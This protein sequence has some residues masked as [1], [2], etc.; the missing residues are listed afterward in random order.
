MASVS[1]GVVRLIIGHITTNQQY[2]L[3]IKVGQSYYLRYQG[4]N[5]TSAIFADRILCSYVILEQKLYFFAIKY[6]NKH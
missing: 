6:P 4:T 1:N 2:V 3:S 5:Q